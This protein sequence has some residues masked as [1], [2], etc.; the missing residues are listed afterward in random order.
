M[1]L[2]TQSN[3]PLVLKPTRSNLGFEAEYKRRL[4]RLVEEMQTSL[5]YW[6]T[7]AY[8]QNEPEV[9]ALDASPAKALQAVI[10]R[11]RRRWLKNFDEASKNLAKFFASGAFSYSEWVLKK[12]LRDAGFTVRFKLTAPMNDAYQAVAAENVGLIRSIAERHLTDVQG[13]VMRSVSQGR[14]L[15]TLSAD[16]Q[17]AYGVTKRRAALIA[18]D[19]NNKATAV[20]TKTRQQQLGITRAKWRHSHGGKVPRRTHL[21]NDGKVYDIAKGW[22][23]PDVG[24]YIFPGQLI[25]CRCTSQSVIPGL[26]DDED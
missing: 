17:A 10:T 16:L 7:A 19:Q 2:R 1:K 6:L 18:R 23:D 4:V 5:V 24:E 21:A 3:K 11:L 25:N 26:D 22:Y 9:L 14:D 12:I 15:G 8:K 13:M 20:F